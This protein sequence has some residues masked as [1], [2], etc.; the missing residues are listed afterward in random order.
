MIF[1]YKLYIILIIYS[2]SFSQEVRWMSIGDLHNWYSA[3]GS[4]IEIGRT[5]QISDQQD[6]LRYPAFYRA[7]DN[8]AAKAMVGATNFYDPIVNKA[9]THKVV[10][11]GPRHLDIE[12]ETIPVKLTMD[13]RHDHT[14]V[15]V[16][17]NPATNL[18]YS[19]KVDNIDPSLVSDRRI[20]NIV[21]TTM[22]VE[23]RRTIYAFSIQIIRII[24][25]KNISLKI[26]VVM[27]KIVT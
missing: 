18:Q 5:G 17:N 12:S 8:Q 15:L 23:M 2:F 14:N 19:D 20:N 1:N 9:Y 24:I 6:G 11:A 26:M 25:F 3:A 13:G 10:H 4:E 21:Q 16:D 22:G 7:Q 27:I